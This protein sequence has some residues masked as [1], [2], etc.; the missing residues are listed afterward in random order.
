VRVRL[1]FADVV[2]NLRRALLALV[3][4]AAVG[5]CAGDDSTDP[6]V[7]TATTRATTGA[8]TAVAA[9]NSASSVTASAPT[10][11]P[12]EPTPATVPATD[13]PQTWIDVADARLAFTLALPDEH[14]VINTLEHDLVGD[15]SCVAP[16]WQLA[17]G[18][19]IEAWPATCD[20]ANSEPGNGSFGHYRTPA[21]APSPIDPIEVDT[22]LGPAD[23]FG[24]TYFE[25]TNS[26]DEW[27]L[28]VAV[29]TLSEPVN[30]EYP[31]LTVIGTV[32]SYT[33]ADLLALL[34]SFGAG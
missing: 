23:V 18:I 15:G 31:T 22:V 16:F 32:K 33:R 17:G 28:D 4:V 12:A 21:D 30:D 1:P 11:P 25:C 14:P 20:P 6:V 10:T 2:P 3:V 26:C 5:A 8:T 13:A 7:T 27:E 9:T 19:N 34:E 29:I 24:Q